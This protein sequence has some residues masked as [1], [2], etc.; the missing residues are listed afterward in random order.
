MLGLEYCNEKIQVRSQKHCCWGTIFCASISYWPSTQCC[1]IAFFT[2]MKN[3]NIHRILKIFYVKTSTNL[4]RGTQQDWIVYHYIVGKTRDLCIHV[5]IICLQIHNIVNIPY[6]I[7]K[8]LQNLS[9]GFASHL[10]LIKEQNH[11]RKKLSVCNICSM[12]SV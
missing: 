6:S 4:F 7:Y 5:C 1:H 11:C 10:N 8:M 9:F 3:L 2:L 12:Q